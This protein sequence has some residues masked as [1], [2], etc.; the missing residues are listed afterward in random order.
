VTRVI[1]PGGIRTLDLVT[2]YGEYLDAEKNPFTGTVEFTPTAWLSDQQDAVI[3]PQVP[4]VV[5][6]GVDGKFSTQ[7]VSTASPGVN[8][9]KWVYKIVETI[10]GYTRVFYA[11]IKESMSMADLV[12]LVDPQEWLS[13]RGPRGYSVLHG[14]RDPLPSDGID[15]DFWV[16][17]VSHR[18][19]AAKA[20]GAWGDNWFL[21]GE[22]APG[23]PGPKGDPGAVEVY[24]QADKPTPKGIGAFWLVTS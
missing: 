1:P 8:P 4:V 20:A 19:W 24:R 7:L 10:N 3:V 14:D 23:P 9:D 6:L 17:Q 13:T 11:E 16:N 22:G 18:F 12:P 15:G 2:V 21:G 5:R